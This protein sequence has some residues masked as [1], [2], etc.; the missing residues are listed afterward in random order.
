[1]SQGAAPRQARLERIF[2]NTTTR[3]RFRYLHE[4]G[5]AKW[6]E[7][8]RLTGAFRNRTVSSLIKTG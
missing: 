4:L 5:A 7:I 3:R 1:V 6:G 8:F 2:H